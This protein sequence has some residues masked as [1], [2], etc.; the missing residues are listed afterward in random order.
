MDDINLW[1]KFSIILLNIDFIPDV[2]LKVKLYLHSFR[3]R[4]KKFIIIKIH[5]F[6]YAGGVDKSITY[7]FVKQNKWPNFTENIPEN[8][9][10]Y[11]TS[12][13][14]ILRLKQLRSVS[15][16]KKTISQI[17]SSSINGDIFRHD[18]YLKNCFY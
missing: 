7:A 8:I 15:Q 3:I 9:A 17:L 13:N 10:V 4:H 12:Y 1:Y 16:V 5:C 14:E 11:E 2:E 6:F 18:L